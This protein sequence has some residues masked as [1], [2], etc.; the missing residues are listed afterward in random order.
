MQILLNSWKKNGEKLYEN[1]YDYE[2]N[3]KSD[4]LHFNE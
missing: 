4:N 3:D 1:N 2:N